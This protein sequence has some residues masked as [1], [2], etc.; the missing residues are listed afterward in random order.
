MTTKQPSSAAMGWD[1]LP[2]FARPPV[3]E[4]ALAV[5]FQPL[6]HLRAVQ[7]GELWSSWRELYPIIDEQPPLPPFTSPTFNRGLSVSFGPPPINRQWFLSSDGD[8]LVQL[9]SDRLIVNWR[10]TAGQSYP[11][12]EEL[13]AECASRLRDVAHFSEEGGWGTL[14]LTDIE[15]TYVNVVVDAEGRPARAEDVLTTLVAAPASDTVGQSTDTR[16]VQTFRAPDLSNLDLTVSAGPGADARGEPALVMTV[17][18]R[19][20]VAAADQF[21]ALTL[22]DAAHVRLVRGFTELTRPTM[23]QLW[24][25][26]S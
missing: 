10:E 2:D 7:L 15:L 13:R 11:R 12:Y 20:T 6:T 21:A 3:R 25:R 8:R 23:H 1:G 4:V 9:Q 22:L 18:V 24:G 19:G 5:G 16:V 26:T 17:V 14:N